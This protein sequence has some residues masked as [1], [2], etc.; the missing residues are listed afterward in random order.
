[1][2]TATERT[3]LR[4]MQNHLSNH[5]MHNVCFLRSGQT[6]VQPIMEMCQLFVIDPQQV[7]DRRVKVVDGHRIDGGS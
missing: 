5:L 2:H 1:M 4:A 6:F 3:L 7:Q